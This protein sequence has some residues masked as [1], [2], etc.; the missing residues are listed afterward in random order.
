MLWPVFHLMAIPLAFMS[1]W[2][3]SGRYLQTILWLVPDHRIE[4]VRASQA[5]A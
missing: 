5:K 3:A 1:P 4:R 2:M